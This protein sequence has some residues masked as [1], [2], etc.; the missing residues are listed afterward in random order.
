MLGHKFRH[1]VEGTRLFQVSKFPFSPLRTLAFF[2]RLQTF[3]VSHFFETMT[4]ID[5]RLAEDSIVGVK[6]SLRSS[7]RGAEEL[8]EEE[9][10]I[11]EEEKM[12]DDDIFSDDSDGRSSMGRSGSTGKHAAGDAD[13]D[14]SSHHYGLRKRR[15][16]SGSDLERLEMFQCSKA[17][18]LAKSSKPKPV[19]SKTVLSPASKAMPPPGSRGKKTKSAQ[20]GLDFKDI[21]LVPN[22]LDGF[23]VPAAPTDK[24]KVTISKQPAS[25]RKRGYSIDCK[26]TCVSMAL[27]L[28]T[29]ISLLPRSVVVYI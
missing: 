18:G 22:P 1:F 26:Y 13:D 11:Q 16:Q 12:M 8:L 17:G 29:V 9:A 28:E 15:R 21:S 10:L 24:R 19:P 20:K 23:D 4:T 3:F 25:G 27:L 14:E 5:N 2:S 6:H 7:T